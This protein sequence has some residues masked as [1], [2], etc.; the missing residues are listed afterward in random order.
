MKDAH[1][2]SHDS[3]ARNDEKVLMLRAELGWEG[4]GIFWALIEMMFDNADTCL[5]HDKIKGVAI[6]NN[7]DITLLQSVINTCIANGLFLSDDNAFWS[8]SLRKRKQKYLDEKEKKSKAG[9]LGMASRWGD[10]PQK[11]S[12]RCYNG[13]ITKDNKLNKLNKNNIYTLE[14]E[15]LYKTHPRPQ[16]KRR[17]FNN[18]NACLKHYS[19]DELLRACENYGKR[20]KAEGTELKYIKTSANFFGKEKPFEDY[21]DEN[22]EPPAKEKES[23]YREVD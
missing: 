13:D 2:F 18:F 9:K 17:T 16:D 4:Y 12:K 8:E 22:Y 6:G 19:F 1:Y 11:K 15:K 5:H 20:M 21:L 3:N 7:I 14:F 10:K 23:G